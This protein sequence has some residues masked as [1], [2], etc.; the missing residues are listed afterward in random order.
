MCHK[1]TGW[2]EEKERHAREIGELTLLWNV[3]LSHRKHAHQIHRVFS[4]YDP[5]C[6][7]EV[8]NIAPRL[9]NTIDKIIEINRQD[10]DWI[11]IHDLSLDR[12]ACFLDVETLPSRSHL[13]Y[14]IGL[15]IRDTHEYVYWMCENP[16]PHDERTILDR[17]HEFV[18][19]RSLGTIYYWYAEKRFFRNKLPEE[20]MR[21]W[22][23]LYEVFW[24]TPIVIKDC[25]HYK[26]KHIARV[27]HQKGKI[28]TNLRD[29]DCG[30]GLESIRIAEEY[31]RTRN[32]GLFEKIYRYNR[33]DCKVLSDIVDVLRRVS[34]DN[35]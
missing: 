20:V 1:N 14:F 22:V 25:F 19:S 32:P 6:S 31:Y 30:D 17:F 15:F 16:T 4:F 3:G 26:L 9:R 7:A 35:H 34:E 5:R 21:S 10:R 24:K 23:D 13:I 8:M 2:D 28:E 33:F 27:L 29:D 18:V 12:S 11:W